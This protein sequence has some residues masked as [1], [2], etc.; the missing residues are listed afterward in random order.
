MS[1]QTQGNGFLLAN[2][3]G[4]PMSNN[5]SGLLHEHT[6]LQQRLDDS[7]ISADLDTNTKLERSKSELERTI[8]FER[9]KDYREKLKNLESERIAANDLRNDFQAELKAQAEKVMQ[10]RSKAFDEQETHNQLQARLYHL[11][12]TI[13][14]TRQTI[15]ELKAELAAHLKQKLYGGN[16][17]GY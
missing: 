6:Q 3:R 2:Y 17:N 12:N 4:Q 16:D 8:F 10:A 15:N 13:E 1:L 11:D 9:T 7:V 5:L 14:V